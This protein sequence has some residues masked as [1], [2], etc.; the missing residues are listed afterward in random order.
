MLTPNETTYRDVVDLRVVRNF[1]VEPLSDEHQAAILEAG[2]WT[3]S[4][5]NRQNWVF[6]AI[7]SAEQRR[8][9]AEAGSFTKPIRDAAWVIALVE[10][11]DGY[12]DAFDIGRA[13]QN[14][15]LAAAALGVGSCPITLHQQDKAAQVLEL[16][17]DHGCR[18]A[19]AL[20]YPEEA[21]EMAAR[22]ASSMGGRKPLG[23]VVRRE[24]F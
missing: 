15:M 23:E 11:P 17:G 24:R 3:G 9:L 10:G 2:R 13:A 6:V 20:G 21:T 4:S 22:S 7:E 8:A 16:P 5:K 1:R 14:I 12:G 19:I 18:Y